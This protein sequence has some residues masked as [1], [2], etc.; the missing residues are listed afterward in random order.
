MMKQYWDLQDKYEECYGHKTIVLIEKGSFYESYATDE[1]GNAK[2]LSKVL[3]MAL[4][5]SNKNK[6]LSLSNPYMSGFPKVAKDKHLGLLS[7][8]SITTVLVDQ[9]WD[10]NMLE[11][12]DRKVTRIITPGTYIEEPPSDESYNICS[13]YISKNN[14]V[15]I[16]IIDLSIGKVTT[17]SCKSLED[18]NRFYEMYNPI[19]TIVLEDSVNHTNFNYSN[20]IIKN[21]KDCKEYLDSDY[22]NEIFKTIYDSKHLNLESEYEINVSLA[23]LLNHIWC[24]HPKSIKTLHI[25]TILYDEDFLILHN[26]ASSQLNLITTKNT[27]KINSLFDVIN[28]TSTSMGKRHLKQCMLLPITNVEQL[29]ERYQYIESFIP[30]INDLDVILKNIHDIERLFKKLVTNSFST[31]DLNKLFESYKHVKQV[32]QTINHIYSCFDVE[33]IIDAILKHITNLFDFTNDCFMK[34]VNIDLDK[35]RKEFEFNKCKLEN[36]LKN[37][38]NLLTNKEN[39]LYFKIEYIEKDGYHVT[40]TPKRAETLKTKIKNLTIKKQTSTA[41]IYN[42]PIDEYC[43]NMNK[44][45]DKY[46]RLFKIEFLNKMN[47][48]YNIFNEDLS[49]VNF[50]LKEIDVIK[51][52]AKLSVKNG[53]IRPTIK[54]HDASYINAKNIRHPIIEQINNEC[55]YIGNDVIFDENNKGLLLYGINSSGKSSYSKSIA[56]CIILAQMGCFVPADYFEYSP[57]T[58]L[59]IR[60]NSDDNMFKN[61]SSFGVEMTELKKIIQCANKNSIVIGDELC[62]GTEDTSA[63]SLVAASVKWLLDNSI[64][65]IFATHLH[66]LPTLDILK[67]DKLKIKHLKCEFNKQ[68][69]RIVF[70]RKLE[71]GSGDT[72]YGIEIARSILQCPNLINNAMYIR[73][74]LTKKN[75]SIINPKKSKYNSKVFVNCCEHCKSSCHNLHTHHIIEQQEYKTCS[76][77]N[78]TKMNDKHNLV[79]L[80]NKCH[81]MIHNH[82]LKIKIFDIGGERQLSFDIIK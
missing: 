4:T 23:Y 42:K 46:K 57:F 72:L 43:M 67:N 66:K 73:N 33:I 82:T 16:T 21:I 52:M 74:N 22:Q 5:K 30:Y 28:Q 58:Q 77:I 60:I 14:R 80:C 1:K 26:T 59:F 81:E 48:M 65:F 6:E 8:N 69:Q 37:Y 11:I 49:K 76:I 7:S 32:F 68:L 40:C 31:Y 39:E 53:Y 19:E 51:S 41:K 56:L 20:V 36:E 15:G 47:E 18:V 27:H 50:V 24:C 54:Q 38:T 12:V 9:I 75:N 63:T 3:N 70:H 71:D 44:M 79:I 55:N 13:I 29:K 78:N 17:L 64:S 35:Y 25:P 61:L 2:L 10:N 62:K 34:N 45:D